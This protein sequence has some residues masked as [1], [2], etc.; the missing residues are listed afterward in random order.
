M[1]VRDFQEPTSEF[2]FAVVVGSLC[3]SF[4]RIFNPPGDDNYRYL[5][6]V[7]GGVQNFRQARPL[8]S[9][10]PVSFSLSLLRAISTVTVLKLPNLDG[11]LPLGD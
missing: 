7:P 1:I 8:V 9:G 3:S 10:S 2:R 4:S 11:T 5:S 6:T